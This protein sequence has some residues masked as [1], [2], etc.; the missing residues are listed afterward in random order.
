MTRRRELPQPNKRLGPSLF[1]PILCLKERLGVLRLHHFPHKV[2]VGLIIE[3]PEQDRLYVLELHEVSRHF[4]SDLGLAV[5]RR[6]WP[7]SK[8]PLGLRLDFPHLIH[9]RGLVRI[10]PILEFVGHSRQIDVLA[11]R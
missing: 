5:R 9:H 6:R 10:E 3:H 1:L 2:G 8:Y 7:I 4:L 11:L